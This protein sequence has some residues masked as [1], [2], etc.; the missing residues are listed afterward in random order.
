MWSIVRIAGVGVLVAAGSVVAL[1]AAA[2][3]AWPWTSAKLADALAPSLGLVTLNIDSGRPG[4][5]AWQVRTADLDALTWRARLTDGRIEYRWR[6][7]IHG[8][9][10]SVVL[11]ELE[12]VLQGGEEAAPVAA[13]ARPAALFAAL[14]AERLQIH[15]L[16]VQ[17]PDLDFAA[18]GSVA[19]SPTSLELSLRGDRPE[20]V[21]GLDLAAVLTPDG[22]FRVRLEPPE[23]TEGPPPRLDVEGRLVEQHI[24]FSGSYELHAE[25]L[26]LLSALLDLPGGLASLS[27]QLDGAVPWPP[28]ALESWARASLDGTVTARWP[29]QEGWGPQ[30]ADVRWRLVDSVLSGEGDAVFGAAARRLPV[31]V[32]VD[33]WRLDRS[34]AA[35]TAALRIEGVPAELAAA[36]LNWRLRDELATLEVAGHTGDR[37]W[38]V[39]GEILPWLPGE[40][41][42]SGRAL[43]DAPWPLP[44]VR[45]A[46]AVTAAV[47]ATGD[48]RGRWQSDD[49]VLGVD[50]QSVNWRWRAGALSGEAAGTVAYDRARVPVA[51]TVDET[52]P[53][54]RPLNIAGRWRIDDGA[55]SPFA[56]RVDGERGELTG[57]VE[58]RIRNGLLADWAPGWRPPFDATAGTVR[59][60]VELAWSPDGGALGTVTVGLED[61]AGHYDEVLLR[62]VSG[63]LELHAE[64]DGWRLAPSRVRAQAL[65]AGVSMTDVGALVGWQG[66][67]LH[68]EGAAAQLLGGTV[69]AAPFTYD[70][71]TGDA[72]IA[73]RFED[74]ALAEVLALE[75]EHVTGTGTLQGEVP[76][77]VS[78]HRPAVSLGRVRA[79]APGGVIRLAPALAGGVGQP[80]LDF[81]LRA[82]QNF[83]YTELDADVDYTADG[84]LTLA[85]RLRGRNP[86]VEAGRPI[87]YNLT[88]QENVPVL[89]ES[90]RLQRRVTEGV[91]RRMRN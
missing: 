3:A 65:D 8:R 13:P 15:A 63:A 69:G 16:T 55:P 54:A 48:L 38:Q 44:A 68:V 27:G 72:A 23:S 62:G 11:G 57:L 24:A 34:E 58:H 50:A 36:T 83:T 40:A 12:L 41:T 70:L 30:Q 60:R 91:E 51:V 31:R 84:D 88:V 59:A 19:V 9:L 85:V 79:D 26:A 81:A 66:D 53:T 49:G 2:Y 67:R 17:A 33:A 14:P 90:L 61:V 75:G 29:A 78:G 77:T 6:D 21:R 4:S 46:A 43:I 71:A 35:G 22:A 28:M 73:V 86:D 32:V 76:V 74:V 89:L 10:V 7:L 80:G 25:T 56:V 47:Q 87:H 18:R 45:D 52:D 82:L 20:A 39:L 64:A 37:G 1:L 42:V 5:G